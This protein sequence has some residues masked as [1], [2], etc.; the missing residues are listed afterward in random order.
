[1]SVDLC[2]L[3][4]PPLS[5]EVARKIPRF[6]RAMRTT[7]GALIFVLIAFVIAPLPLVYVGGAI[8]ILLWCG[9]VKPLSVRLFVDYCSSRF[10]YV[11]VVSGL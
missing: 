11:L 7:F 1:M 2:D 8:P 9:L 3:R 6:Q 5:E 4:R 10:F